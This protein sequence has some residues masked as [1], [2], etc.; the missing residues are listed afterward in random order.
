MPAEDTKAAI[1]DAAAAE[2]LARG[3]AGASMSS[4]ADRIG[5]TKGALTYHFP[6]KADFAAHFIR[7]VRAATAQARAF[8]QAEY[9]DRPARRLLLHFLV[10]GAWRRSEPGFAAG[11]ALFADSASPAFEADEV[12]R[13]W[14]DLSVDA[15]SS[16]PE[17]DGETAVLEAAEMFLAT[18]LGAA[19]FGRHVRLN[20][21]G[22]QPLR[23]VRLALKAVGVARV[24]EYAD[25]VI[26]QYSG[27]IPALDR[28]ATDAP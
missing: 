28:S 10:M 5:L 26:A 22:T 4:I 21:P 2:F 24:D 14:L 13:D 11:M 3:Y 6:T 20:A 15:L 8:S 1:A 23:F 7:V 18:N 9:G 12:I 16:A 19:V 27:R 17:F 25:E